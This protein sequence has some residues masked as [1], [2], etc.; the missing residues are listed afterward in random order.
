M[1]TKQALYTIQ[2]DTEWIWTLTVVNTVV[3]LESEDGDQ[4]CL[5]DLDESIAAVGEIL[6]A[7][8]EVKNGH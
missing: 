2:S 1:L 3:R 7:L 8:K 4:L 5:G 6:K